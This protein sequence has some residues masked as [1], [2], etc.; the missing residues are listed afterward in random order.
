[1]YN[2]LY[3]SSEK[4]GHMSDNLSSSNPDVRAVI[5]KY[6]SKKD[7]IPALQGI[8]ENFGFISEEN[9]IQLS[10]QLNV[11]LVEISGVATFYNM[12]RL[13]PVGKYH[14]ALCRGTACHVQNSMHV[15]VAAL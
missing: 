6:D 2:I 8:Q 15:A 13:K 12:F 7:T 11:P 14:I 5:K 3:L 10:K 9:S 1:M 4:E